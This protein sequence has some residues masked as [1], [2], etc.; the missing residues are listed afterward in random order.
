MG[1]SKQ[2]HSQRRK[3]K[4]VWCHLLSFLKHENQKLERYQLNARKSPFGRMYASHDYHLWF[5]CVGQSQV[6]V[7]KECPVLAKESRM[8][9]YLDYHKQ[10][11]LTYMIIKN[12][13]IIQIYRLVI[14]IQLANQ[15]V[16][17][18]LHNGYKNSS[19][20]RCQSTIQIEFMM[21]LLHGNASSI[22]WLYEGYNHS[23][24][25]PLPKVPVV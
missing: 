3:K 9:H 24:G 11:L 10:A 16:K 8:C 21:N 12:A 1:Q 5:P 2:I 13:R 7:S 22:T 20:H 4:Q 18:R 25:E 15:Q 14:N 23:S 17:A 6:H 19:C